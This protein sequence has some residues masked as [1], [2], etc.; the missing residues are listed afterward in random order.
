MVG[1]DTVFVSG[2]PRETIMVHFSSNPS[3]I[4]GRPAAWLR[5][6]V[7]ALAALAMAGHAGIAQSQEGQGLA[8]M[9]TE[10]APMWP[11]WEGRIGVVL[12]HAVDPARQNFALSLPAS[13]GLKLRGAHVLSDYYFSGGFRATAGLVHGHVNLPWGSAANTSA[14]GLNL[15]MDSM[16]L[17]NLPSTVA[18]ND[19]SN[20]VVPYLG[21]GYS[22]HLTAQASGYGA[23]RFNADLGVISLNSGNIGRLGRVLQGDQ[24]ADELLRDLRLRPVVKIRVDYAF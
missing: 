7:A 13:S 8:W 6:A 20:R 24:G 1:M 23:W 17:A 14:S 16:D 3:L 22:T 5:P 10:A 18:A 19:E 4:S 15:S 11:H 9:S 2:L 21:A 12:D